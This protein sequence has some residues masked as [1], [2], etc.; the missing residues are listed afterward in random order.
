MELTPAGI[1]TQLTNKSEKERAYFRAK[2][3][4]SQLVAVWPGNWRSDLFLIDDMDEF[5]KANGI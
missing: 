5:A 2:C 4:E 1:L 3:G